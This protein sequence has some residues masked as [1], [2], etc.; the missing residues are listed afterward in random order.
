MLQFFYI[1]NALPILY[2]FDFL[3]YTFESSHMLLTH[4]KRMLKY[5]FVKS[6]L[7]L[8]LYPNRSKFSSIL[9]NLVLF[10]LTSFKLLTTM[11]DHEQ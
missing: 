7:I 11:N 4:L 8:F 5:F 10:L 3:T 6:V 9:F 2:T 1:E